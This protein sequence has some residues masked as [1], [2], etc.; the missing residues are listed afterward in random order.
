MLPRK[1]T[2]LKIPL[3]F[4]RRQMYGHRYKPYNSDS[5]SSISESDSS[6]T[7]DSEDVEEGFQTADFK[8]FAEDLT[9]PVI[10]DLSSVI[11]DSFHDQLGYTITSTGVL[12]PVKPPP[13]SSE[14]P[15]FESSS[16]TITSV[17]MIESIDRDTSAFPQPTNLTLRLPRIYKNVTGFSIIQIKLLSAFYYF[18]A[19]KENINISILEL[20]RTIPDESGNPL[21]NIIKNTIRQGTYD[22]NALINELTVQLNNPP[23][24][25]D[26]INGFQDFA[27]KFAVTGD[28]SL[29]F[30]YPGDT[31]FD[32]LL[33]QYISNPTM[34]TI[35]SKYF[36]QQYGNLPSYTN[37]QIKVAYYYPVLKEAALDDVYLSSINYNIV[38]SLPYLLDTE[39]PYSR[40]VYTF[41]GINDPVIVE[42]INLNV[43]ILTDYRLKHTFRY[44]LINKYVISYQQ[45]SN[46]IS[47]SSPSL[48]TS[49][50]NLLNYKRAQYLAEQIS[51]YGLTQAEYANLNS[52]TENT[53]AVLTD[54]V[55]YYQTYL[56]VYF[57][58]PYNTY[59]FNYL[60]DQ[61]NILPIRDA[62]NAVGISSNYSATVQ[63][64]PISTNVLN[65]F[66]TNPK[67]YWNGMINLP[68]TTVAYMNPVLPGESGTAGI[69][70]YTWNLD[71]DQQDTRNP[72]VLNNII[73][74]NN[75]NTTPIGNLYINRRTAT[76]E[77]IIP[78][79]SSKYTVFRFKSPVRQT[80]R[81]ETLPRPTKYRYPAY[82]AVTYDLSNQRVFDASYSFI[83][84]SPYV[85]II[86]D[87]FDSSKIKY[88]P[89]FSTFGSVTPFGNN[90]STS[91]AYWGSNYIT[92]SVID[93]RAFY[94]FYTPYPPN[95]STIQ[96]PAY[97]YPFSLTFSHSIAGQGLTTPMNCFVYQ[98]RSAFMADISGNGNENPLHYSYYVSTVAG[99]SSIN[100]D[101]KA[102]ANKRY[103]VLIRPISDSFATD[104]IKIVPWFPSSMFYTT[105]T[106]TLVGF[107][108]LADP[109]SNLNNYNYAQVADPDFLHIPTSSN[110]YTP[111]ILDT[112]FSPLTFNQVLMGYDVSGVSTDLTNYIG[113][114]SN[115][116]GSN[117]VPNAKFR[118]DPTNGFI[119]QYKTAYNRNTQLYISSG[120]LN[121]LLYPQG[122][123]VYSNSVIPYRQKSIVNWYGNVFIPPSKNQII[124]PTNAIAF[125][126]IL[127]YTNTFPVSTG[128]AGYNYNTRED[129]SGN[130]Y[131]NTSNLIDFG[132]GVLGI[133]FLPEEGVWNIDRF[134][135]KSIFTSSDSNIDPNLKTKFIGIF[136]AVLT[137]NRA[138]QSIA[139]S[140]A[141]AIL[142]F[143]SSITYN[144]S[145]QNLGF[146]VVG[147]TYYEFTRN[148]SYITGS[149][150]YLYGYT[151]AAYEYNFD[152]NMYY[153]AIPFTASSNLNYY[154]GLVGSAVPYPL[155]TSPVTVN[156]VPSPEGPISTPLGTDFI[157]PGS[158]IPGA[159]SI[160]GPPT[161]FTDTESKYE[162]SMTSVT[163]LIL[164]VNPYAINTVASVYNPAEPL[165]YEPIQIIGDCSGFIMTY[166]SIFRVYSYLNTTSNIDLHE[167]QQFTLDEVFP[168]NS[169][170]Q[171]LGVSANES[172]YAFFGLSNAVTNPY[173][174]IRTLDPVSGIIEN[175]H[176]EISP[177]AF[178]SNVQLFKTT[179]NNFG[180]YTL[181]A[182]AYNNLTS[183]S[184]VQVVSKAS[185][186]TSTFTT[187]TYTPTQ[188]NITNFIV[189]QSPKE[190][191]GRFWVFPYRSGINGFN[192]FLHVNPN[193]LST[194]TS[195][196]DY[197]AYTYPYYGAPSEDVK[198]T[199]I[200]TYTLSNTYYSPIVTRDVALDR[201]YFL[202]SGNSTKFYEANTDSFT[203]SVKESV[204]S[205]PSTPTQ[206]VP[207]ANGSQW[208][209]I[210]TTILGNRGNL[211]D[212]PKTGSQVW[213][214]F[215]PVQRI[216]FH[217]IAKNFTFL[218]DLS[219][220]KYPEYPHTAIAIYDS[221]GAFTN[222]TS[223]KWGLESSQNFITGD[224]NTSGYYFN[225]YDYIVPLYDNRSTDDYY[226]MSIRNYFPTE[227]SQVTLRVSAPNKYTFGYVTPIDLSGEI[228]TAQSIV[229]TYSLNNRYWDNKYTTS[230]LDFNSKFTFGS[231]GVIFG[232]GIIP[233]FAGSNISSVNG[234]GDFYSRIKATF[235]TYSTLLILGSTINS[236]VKLNLNEFVLSDLKYI[237]PVSAQNRQRVTDPLRYSIRWKSA[238]SPS[239]SKIE[240]NW[241]LGWN[242]GFAKE[243]TPFATV[244]FAP[245]FF[246]LVDDYI[247][248]RMNPEFDLNR[249]D[250]VEKEN[251]AVSLETTGITKAYYGKLLLANFGSYA[252]TLISNPIAFLNPVGKLDKLTFQWLDITNTIINNNDCEWN[253]VIQITEKITIATPKVDTAFNQTLY[254]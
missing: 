152:I 43:D 254:S 147:G 186:Q 160:F 168:Q 72:I 207:G 68:S 135:F 202:S 70:Y 244:H 136:P 38:T 154:Y 172:N 214:I 113:F 85:D 123:A 90:Y 67:Q 180:G 76:S 101:F 81:V 79:E 32:S 252:Q 166:D 17:I 197:N 242:L 49:L 133:G 87:N 53:L 192:N 212:A 4:G 121:T 75:P 35:I 111:P 218:L 193:N 59:S 125:P 46:Q 156:S 209:N 42:L 31:F 221:S 110:L 73:D 164:Y 158:Q 88:I 122:A 78:T 48:N 44:T 130:T 29:N 253:A 112:S 230:I 247:Q 140:N 165:T 150:S 99:L 13:K 96:A 145:N 131:L 2:P 56:A 93:P 226:Y 77:V 37:D 235:S 187:L 7:T 194:S 22:I 36:L 162:Q 142:S 228:S 223:G 128:V 161:G 108:P 86:S 211:T 106:S 248:L 144:S 92:V 251:L 171:Y 15:L 41:Q 159:N 206:I 74:S 20:A 84:P 179:Y 176:S 227:K 10:T 98:D 21:T 220:R 239:Y 137:S 151:Q 80:L 175:S 5:E 233:G 190:E 6:H 173:I 55:N 109:S 124:F 60:L 16:Q 201:I 157:I 62:Y 82:N 246:K 240:N 12:N 64:A 208:A 118:T 100:L 181:S 103:Y 23:I 50:V 170:I 9:K 8:K 149:N 95:Y 134:M 237:I 229:S 177:L 148:N 224:F 167:V 185:R 1:K 28:F 241:G 126:G 47:F 250:S 219:G 174:H 57:G 25:Y 40:V 26:Y 54:M 66:R 69:N 234:F 210:Y 200:N 91:V 104:T 146:D 189:Q 183:T 163:N 117:S 204:Y 195:T 249:M 143:T 191:F 231:T 182:Q 24:F 120:T 52:L 65:T 238:L 155:Y 216:V 116:V 89:G 184:Y 199:S 217:Q 213:Q 11:V 58:I 205:F 97:T 14:P 203:P 94:S 105:L 236:Q 51:Y 196:P 153:L 19:A 198:Y 115:T 119:F 33:N 169:N 178:Q 129:I 127:P 114:L 45:Q 222:D 245:S 27:Q 132:D 107:D 63:T 243:D 39:T 188:T 232:N 83:E 138:I 3:P 225:A 102:Y 34:A 71:M 61:N 141:L 139:L 18:R 30:N 215:N